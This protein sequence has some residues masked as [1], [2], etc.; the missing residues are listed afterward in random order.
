[1]IKEEIDVVFKLVQTYGDSD[2]KETNTTYDHKKILKIFYRWFKLGPREFKEVDNPSETMDVRLRPV[3]N[4]LV[5]KTFL[6]KM[7]IEN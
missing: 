1:M 5:R 3:K 7:I 4:T 6:Q 2:G